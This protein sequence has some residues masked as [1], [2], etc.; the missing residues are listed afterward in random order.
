LLSTA[1]DHRTV[2]GWMDLDSAA[3]AFVGDGNG[4]ET[5]MPF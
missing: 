2:A 4:A 5:L 1:K 3:V